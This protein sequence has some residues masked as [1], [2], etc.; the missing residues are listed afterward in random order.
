MQIW[1]SRNHRVQVS[2]FSEYSGGSPRLWSHSE[3]E[4]DDDKVYDH[5][6]LK[7]RGKSWKDLKLPRAHLRKP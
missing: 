7:I 3:L 6:S 5:E 4:G 1:P 2:R